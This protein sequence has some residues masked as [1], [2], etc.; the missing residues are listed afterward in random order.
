MNA[1]KFLLTVLVFPL[2]L[3]GC[4]VGFETDKHLEIH[5]QN[6]TTSP[7]EISKTP[8]AD[9]TAIYFRP[10]LSQV[11]TN[12][13][14]P[15]KRINA[16]QEWNRDFST[17]FAAN[18]SRRPFFPMAEFIFSPY[19]HWKAM[20]RVNSADISICQSGGC[21]YNKGEHHEGEDWNRYGSHP[22]L[23]KSS[24]KGGYYDYNAPIVSPC[25]GLIMGKSVSNSDKGF[26]SQVYVL[27]KFRTPWRVR[28]G[29]FKPLE[30]GFE[31]V[32]FKASHLSSVTGKNTGD[33]VQLGEDIGKLGNSGFSTGPH[34]HAAIHRE[35][36]LMR[37]DNQ[38]KENDSG[39][40][41]CER[42][43]GSLRTSQVWPAH[44]ASKDQGYSF[45]RDNY[46]D[47][48]E[49]IKN[50]SGK[51]LFAKQFN[52]GTNP[53]R[54]IFAESVDFDSAYTV[55]V[56]MRNLDFPR[57]N[58]EPRPP[59][60]SL[61]IYT[62]DG[63]LI[64]SG[65]ENWSDLNKRAVIRNVKQSGTYRLIVK[66]KNR[67]YGS[68]MPDANFLLEV[69][70]YKD[71]TPSLG[72][73][74]KPNFYSV[75]PRKSGFGT[76]IGQ[77]FLD[78]HS[79]NSENQK[80]Q[81]MLWRYL[82]VA[83]D[84]SILKCFTHSK[85]D[86]KRVLN[87][88]DF[89][90]KIS[91]FKNYKFNTQA[92]AKVFTDLNSSS[93]CFKYAYAAYQNKVVLPPNGQ[94]PFAFDS[95]KTL[96]RATAVT[97]LVRAFW[98]E[99]AISSPSVFSDIAPKDWFN[100]YF[101]K[102]FREGIILGCGGGK[103]CPADPI[104]EAHADIMFAREL[105]VQ[106]NNKKLIY[107]SN[108]GF[109]ERDG[110]GGGY[111]SNCSCN[112]GQTAFC[113]LDVGQCKTGVITCN[114]NG[115]W[116]D[117]TCVG[118]V[119]AS[120]E[121]C[122]GIDNDCDGQI[123]NIKGTD[124]P[125]SRD[126]DGI[127]ECGTKGI[128]L[129]QEGQWQT[130]SAPTCVLGPECLDN[131]K[132]GYGEG[133]DCI[134]KDCDDQNNRINPNQIEICNGVDD[135]CDGQIDNV[136]AST[137]PLAISCAISP[138][139]NQGQKICQNGQWSQCSAEK[140]EDPCIDNDGDGFFA[141]PSKSCPGPKD[142]DDSNPNV[143]PGALEECDG[144]DND[145]DGQIDNQ[146]FGDSTPL[147]LFC[148]KPPCG[149]EIKISC[150]KGQWEMCSEQKCPECIDQDKDGYKV[151]GVHCNPQDCDDTNSNIF[152]GAKE[153]CNGKDDDC[154]G[155]IDNIAGS[156]DSIYT[157]CQLA[158]GNSGTQT[159]K[160]GKWSACEGI[161]GECK[162]EDKDGF[163]VGGAHCGSKDCDDANPKIHP[164]SL[165]D[166]NGKD[167]DCDGMID[168]IAGNVLK[169]TCNNPSC[170]SAGISSCIAGK[171]SPCSAECKCQDNDLDGYKVG[172]V[173]CGLKDCDDADKTRSPGSVE[174]CDGKDNNC[175]GQVDEGIACQCSLGDSRSCYTGS[176]QS[177]NKGI[178]K[179]GNQLC[180]H[181][182]KGGNIWG[183]CLN[184]ITPSPEICDGK[185]NDCD[186]QIDNGIT[187][188]CIVG[189]TRQCGVSNLGE[190]RM[191]TQSCLS[192][193]KWSECLG[194]IQANPE[195]CDGKD[196]NC[197]G[198]IDEN[199]TQPCYNGNGNTAGVGVCKSGFSRCEKGKWSNLCIGEIKPMIEECD[200]KDNN[201]DGQID[202]NLSRKCF[203][204]HQSQQDVGICNSGQ[205]SCK[206]GTWEVCKG[207]GKAEVEI[208]D[209]K[210]NDCD[211]FIDNRP[212]SNQLLSRACTRVPC[213]FTGIEVCKNGNWDMNSCT[214]ANC[215]DA[216]CEDKDGD[217][218]FGGGG[219]QCLKNDCNDADAQIHPGTLEVCDGKDNDCD[220][221]IDS[222]P[223]S[224]KAIEQVCFVNPCANAG[225][226]TCIGGQWS[227]CVA[228]ACPECTDV[229]GDGYGKGKD[230]KGSDCN[231]ADAKTNP[232]ATEICDG[233]DNDCDGQ[234]DNVKGSQI[235]IVRN[236]VDPQCGNAGTQNCNNGAWNTCKA[237]TPCEF[238][239]NGI[240]NN[241]N[242]NCSSCL[243]DCACGQ[244]QYCDQGLKTCRSNCGNGIV[245]QGE[246]CSNC[247]SDVQCSNGTYCKQSTSSCEATC[248]NGQVDQGENCSNCP[249]DVQCSGNTECQN[250]TCVQKNPCANCSS[251]QVCYQN[252]C[253]T[254]SCQ[255]NT[256]SSNQCGGTCSCS[257]GYTCQ[258]GTCVQ[259]NP[260]ANCSSNQVCYQNACCT[261]S[262]QTN[263]CSSNQCGGTCS[264]LSGYTCQS[265][266]CVQSCNCNSKQYC[267]AGVCKDRF[268]S[269]NLGVWLCRTTN[270]VEFCARFTYNGNTSFT[271]ETRKT[272][273]WSGG[274][275]V[276]IEVIQEAPGNGCYWG[277]SIYTTTALPSG[278][279][280]LSYQFDLSCLRVGDSAGLHIS[281]TSPAG[282]TDSIC[283]FRSGTCSLWRH[284]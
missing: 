254:P 232:A 173:H 218:Y 215:P 39:D 91:T 193:N 268:T 62:P 11:Q 221:Q 191:G 23:E 234:I 60:T 144:K 111:C 192:Q 266:T 162:D 236:C 211:G 133:K 90:E 84:N 42:K 9:Q 26:G 32:A 256:C 151:G 127:P 126:C 56:N 202:E 243:Q 47:A 263:T 204:G 195:I 255:T 238:C 117:S 37:C 69:T 131:D 15:V 43:F 262:C 28:S 203:S 20:T 24:G 270:G 269:G 57:R 244:G 63:N 249:S 123:D 102:A 86:Y 16:L 116:D 38:G 12:W 68:T 85:C 147:N 70:A 112:P 138:C 104:S 128:S 5:K 14:D 261:P 48:L 259:N 224:G 66:G 186:G 183:K 165:E 6:I 2:L 107:G 125:I 237:T 76:D 98:G 242:E 134:A 61:E 41:I 175:N 89:A 108:H 248:G 103:A 121:V 143:Y 257:S 33:E 19:E 93:D 122:D 207:E 53:N 45:I 18:I 44:Y 185:D 58:L 276:R 214:A 247:P 158:C 88:C 208:C 171:W 264:C 49:F 13:N 36:M 163:F 156:G 115:Q 246:N 140:C 153:I 233:K 279:T 149:K 113:G 194:A 72:R 182:N 65:G 283:K 51:L 110:V 145:C 201:C 281:I 245:D 250:G 27:C 81:M 99:Q 206:N 154:D 52:S 184:E 196:N 50:R 83:H 228:P 282:C 198:Q 114:Q 148:F 75:L 106:D 258:S 197:D 74:G 137:D 150:T 169:K 280:I 139:G 30:N 29:S 278:N 253:C 179:S 160:N 3:V 135:D 10:E 178:C 231:D 164:G 73:Y 199:L 252:A 79:G 17:Q 118:E 235:P 146:N 67:I 78:N 34:I 190:C 251:N 272:G 227:T 100:P 170:G 265:G 181:D 273:S 22:D 120:P 212:G 187:C 109:S 180:I 119:K 130:C 176:A 1:L 174:I 177:S 59:L 155:Q 219:S 54:Q 105:G 35:S 172:G 97:M 96:D 21:L 274:Q 82:Q 80:N 87:R 129:C 168:N 8:V 25:K 77:L 216:P 267:S 141:N 4:G 7:I 275:I 225:K 64:L 226:R 217:G 229:D 271:V 240:C 200:G 223:S 71:A 222:D 241:T 220:G 94:I 95:A 124:L 157:N 166:C 159:C 132:D 239:G 230:C 152:A 31:Y 213:G 277:G 260:C 284:N 161:C 188:N 142:C 167:D 210:D 205:Q 189:Q 92:H 136:K 55:M 40:Y 209:G 101:T 46:Y